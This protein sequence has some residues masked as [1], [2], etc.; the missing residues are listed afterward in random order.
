MT[1][2]K[3][4]MYQYRQTL[5]RLRQG[6]YKD[7][8]ADYNQAIAIAPS[9]AWSFYGRGIDKIRLG[10]VPEGQADIEAA[11]KLYAGIA[12]EAANYGIVP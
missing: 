7:S 9:A 1:K 3:I 6:D 8:L 10:E 12:K 11:T 2:R 4:E 5:V